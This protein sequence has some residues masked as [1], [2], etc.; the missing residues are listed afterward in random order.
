MTTTPGP[1]HIPPSQQQSSKRL[2]TTVNVV[3]L[4]VELDLVTFHPNTA[5]TGQAGKQH[6]LRSIA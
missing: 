3:T 5:L 6:S 2:C 4:P 1:L